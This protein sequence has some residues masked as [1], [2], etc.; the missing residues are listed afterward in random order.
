[1]LKPSNP[2]ESQIKPSAGD[3]DVELIPLPPPAERYAIRLW[4]GR[5]EEKEYCLDFV[6]T[7]THLPINSSR[8]PFG[9]I[10]LKTRSDPV[11]YWLNT[12]TPFYSVEHNNGIK[13]DHINEGVEKYIV[14]DAQACSL[15]IRDVCVL[16]FTIPNRQPPPTSA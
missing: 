5:I 11:R 13:A 15:F 4:Q 8:L 12:Y 9:P 3:P 2:Y 16:D 7:T 10:E 14:R 6:D 1:M